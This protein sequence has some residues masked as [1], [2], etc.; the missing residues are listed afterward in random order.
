MRRSDESDLSDKSDNP[1]LTAAAAQQQ[2][3]DVRPQRAAADD[4]GSRRKNFFLPLYVRF[5]NLRRT[6]KFHGRA[7]EAMALRNP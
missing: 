6:L 1:G 2:I 3:D 5:G 4:G 7:R